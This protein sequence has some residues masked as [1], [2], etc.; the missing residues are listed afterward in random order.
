MKMHMMS[1]VK[2]WSWTTYHML[3]AEFGELPLELYALKL[4]TGFQQQLAHPPSS[5]L[6]NQA[7]SLSRHL[8]EEGFNTWHNS[9]TMWK[10]SWDLSCWETH[11]N[12]TTSKFT[13]DDIKEAFLTKEWNSFHTSW[14][15]LDD[16]HVDRF[17]GLGSVQQN[18]T[19]KT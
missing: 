10:A 17:F 5:W 16:L 2:V 7:T 18:H 11:N 14:K 9:T 12:P 4:T 1:H 13:I 15:K 3:L 19:W 6:V 8:A